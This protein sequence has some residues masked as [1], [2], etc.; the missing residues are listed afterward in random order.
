MPITYGINLTKLWGSGE[1]R[2]QN[3]MILMKAYTAYSEKSDVFLSYQRSDQGVALNLAKDLDR[4]GRSVYIDVHDD[5]L[6]PGD[7][8]LDNALIKAIG[9]ADTMVVVVSDDTQGSWWV[10]WE[11]GVSTPF[12]KPKA[13]YRPLVNKPLPL[14]LQKLE[15]LSTATSANQWIVQSK[16]P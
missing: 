15:R 6:I 13:M 1:Q 14:Y 2:L 5:T 11:I 7:Y 10:P 9:N 4:L 16:R 3:T 8:N 12:G